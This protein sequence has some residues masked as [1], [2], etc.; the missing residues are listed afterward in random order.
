MLFSNLPKLEFW[1]GLAFF[2]F[3]IYGLEWMRKALVR[4]LKR[5]QAEISSK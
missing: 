4:Y 3:I 1:I 5:G 2:P